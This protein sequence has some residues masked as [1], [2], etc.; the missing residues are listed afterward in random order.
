M[1][2]KYRFD[3]AML[4]I[5]GQLSKQIGQYFIDPDNY[6]KPIILF[7]CLLHFE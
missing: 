3:F 5:P 4:Q 1:L 2:E 7:I 6:C